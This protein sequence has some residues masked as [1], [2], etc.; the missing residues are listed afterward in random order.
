MRGRISRSVSSFTRWLGGS[1]YVFG[2]F[3]LLLLLLVWLQILRTLRDDKINTTSSAI[4][5]NSNLVVSLEQYA[6]FTV[7]EADEALR[8]VRLQYELRNESLQLEMLKEKGIIDGNY[9][10]GIA[11]LDSSGK[12]V[13]SDM[14]ADWNGQDFSDREYFR[15]H[16]HND[17]QLFIGKPILSRTLGR[18]VIVFSRPIHRQDGGFAGIV[19]IQVEP[20]RFMQFYSQAS[21]Q[22]NDIISLIAPDGITYARRT[23]SIVSHGE[24][25]SK[26]PLFRHVVERPVGNYEAADAIHGI[27]TYFS[28]R[29]LPDLPI[30]ATVGTSKTDVLRDFYKRRSKDLF[31]GMVVTVVII[32]FFAIIYILGK[33]R[34]KVRE[35]LWEEQKKFERELTKQIIVAQERERE[36]IGHEL[37]D[38]VN[39]VLTSVKLFLQMAIN[40]PALV[41]EILPRSVQYLMNCIQE[42][43][44]LSRTLSAP[45]LGNTSFADSIASLIE[46]V[47]DPSGIQIDFV[48]EGPIE[49]IGKDQKLTLY[50]ILQEQLNNVVKHAEATKVTI[51]LAVDEQEVDLTIEDNGKG[52][53]KKDLRNGIGLNNI[54]SRAAVLGGKM[55]ITSKPGVGTMM[56][57]ILPLEKAPFPIT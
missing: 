49:E 10:S 41:D 6:A 15:F 28:Y 33:H 54:S 17:D 40:K 36:I 11:V 50:R 14:S 32:L 26:S 8:M 31:Y 18:D 29:K 43:R 53:N 3:C 13:R 34:R 7:K 12:L 25:I 1:V 5:R 16:K 48:Q 56:M 39:Q 4:Q 44:N 2:L 19:A 30:I 38:N 20:R 23:G 9:F 55:T 35:R 27:P 46:M 47:A 24:D 37:H 45:T 52:F 51:R 57:V 22:T 42:L 21:L